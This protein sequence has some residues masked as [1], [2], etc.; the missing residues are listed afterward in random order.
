MRK[1]SP[2]IVP[3]TA[4][5]A[6]SPS[7]RMAD[8]VALH[9]QHWPLPSVPLH[10]KLLIV[11]GL[12]EHI[13]R[14]QHVAHSLVQQGWAVH[15]YDQRGH[16][17]SEGERGSLP[18]DEAMLRDLSRIIDLLRAE[19][20][21]PLV[22][23]G[24]SMGGAVA[25]RFVAEGLAKAPAPWWRPVDGLVMSSPALD[26]GMNAMQ[27]L[28][29]AVL[30]RVAPDLAMGNGLNPA[31]VSRDAAVVAAYRADPLVHGRITPRLVRFIVT[32]GR[33]VRAVAAHW[34]V[35][36][37]LLYAGKDGLVAS[38]GSAQFAAAAQASLV[39]THCFAELFHEIFNE[40]ERAEVLAALHA[41]L[42]ELNPTA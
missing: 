36:T 19:R 14:Y 21:G 18:D 32:A 25:S 8:G 31:R 7:V 28:M 33:Q 10:G 24:H 42:A 2:S 22:L 35:P 1:D 38:R 29:L 4:P 15:G 39:R 3:T 12:G 11:H 6:L 30:G 5:A 17:R 23:L 37:L 27:K 13:G 40:P 41:W 26:T 9:L 20:S 16:G 34:N